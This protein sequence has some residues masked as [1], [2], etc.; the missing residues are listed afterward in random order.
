MQEERVNEKTRN[1]KDI[2]RETDRDRKKTSPQNT[3]TQTHIFRDTKKERRVR[4]M[5][6][7]SYT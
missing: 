4:S 1:T 6:E 7:Q 5:E 2:D 3:Q